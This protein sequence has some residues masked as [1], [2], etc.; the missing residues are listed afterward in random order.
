MPPCPFCAPR[1]DPR[2][3]L[4][5]EHCCAIWTEE[6]PEGSAMVVPRAHRVTV[7][8]LTDQEWAS[9]RRLLERMRQLIVDLH[10][11]DGWNV[12]WNVDSVGGQQVSHA[13]CHLVPRYRD[14]PLAGRGIRSWIKDPTNRPPHHRPARPPSWATPG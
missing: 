4:S 14:E 1:V 10:A 7:F 11:P 13:H 6:S 12:G 8:D 9:T 3:V 2:I 5:D